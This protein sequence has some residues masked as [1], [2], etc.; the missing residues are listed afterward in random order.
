L[1]RD[2]QRGPQRAAVARS[3]R[4]TPGTC[5]PGASARGSCGTRRSAAGY[6]RA[7]A[8]TVIGILAATAINA[9]DFTTS[10]RSVVPGWFYPVFL[11]IVILGVICNSILSVYS[12]GLSLQALGVPL[13]RSRTV[14]VDVVIGTALAV[15]GVLIAADFLTTLQNFLLWSIYWHAPFFGVYMAELALTYGHYDGHELHRVGGRYWYDRGYRWRGIAALLAG[16]IFAALTSDTP[17]FKGPLSSHVLSGGDK[18]LEDPQIAAD[19][20]NW[21]S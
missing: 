19:F 21:P 13:A 5:P 8:L 15:Y 6:L 2:D 7:V 3:G 1:Q 17:Y 11:L 4:T 9:S 14:W 10:I 18:L 16:M 12:S 20:R